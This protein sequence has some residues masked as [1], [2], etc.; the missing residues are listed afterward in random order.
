MDHSHWSNLT[1][2]SQ[3][4]WTTGYHTLITAMTQNSTPITNYVHDL[5]RVVPFGM[6]KV[7]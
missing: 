6:Y 7:C 4:T 5:D 3:F 2:D 1:S